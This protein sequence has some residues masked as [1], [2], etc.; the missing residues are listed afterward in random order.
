MNDRKKRKTLKKKMKTGGTG[1]AFPSSVGRKPP[2]IAPLN[3]KRTQPR[4]KSTSK[5]KK[6]FRRN[7][8]TRPPPENPPTTQRITKPLTFVKLKKLGSPGK[9]QIFFQDCNEPM[10][11][12]NNV[13]RLIETR[14]NPDIYS[15]ESGKCINEEFKQSN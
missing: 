13:F 4:H 14:Q 8:N 5:S 10:D 3:L 12:A 7:G 9:Y 6:V 11:D 1:P 15:V 2:N